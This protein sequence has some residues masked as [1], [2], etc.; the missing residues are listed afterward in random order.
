VSPSYALDVN[1]GGTISPGNSS[2]QANFV[3]PESATWLL[4]GVGLL[5]TAIRGIRKKPSSKGQ[6]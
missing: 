1:N 5:M 2:A 6:A 4:M 3:V